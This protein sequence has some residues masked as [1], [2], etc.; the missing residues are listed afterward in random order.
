MLEFQDESSVQSLIDACIQDE[1]KLYLCVSSP[2]IKD[3]PVQV[4]IESRKIV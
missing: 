4:S 3:K 1:D 2:T